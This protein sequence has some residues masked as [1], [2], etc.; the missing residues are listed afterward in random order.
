MTVNDVL[1]MDCILTP[2]DLVW[3]VSLSSVLLNGVALE[4]S[5]LCQM[6][7][8]RPQISWGVQRKIGWDHSILFF[9]GI[10][11]PLNCRTLLKQV[12]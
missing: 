5:V 10:Y 4:A 12:Y 7:I 2:D 8:M 3:W 1:S 11:M 9:G 6:S